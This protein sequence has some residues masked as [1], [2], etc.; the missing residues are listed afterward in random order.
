M[1]RTVAGV[2][3]RRAQFAPRGPLGSQATSASGDATSPATAP[4]RPG[5]RAEAPA[6]RIHSASHTVAAQ[7]TTRPSIHGRE[8]SL[9]VPS[10]WIRATGQQAYAVQ[11]TARQPRQPIRDRRTLVIVSARS[12]SK[13]TAPRPSHSGR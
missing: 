5:A 2:P 12:R 3:A 1:A 6:T 9:P 8:A 4:K 7:A 10:P 13:A 11:C